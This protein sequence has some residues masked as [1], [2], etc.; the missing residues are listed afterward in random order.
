MKLKSLLNESTKDYRRLNI[1][2]EEKEQKM[3]SEEKKAFL[4][5]VSAYKKFGETIYRNGDL[6]ET[7]TAI[8]GIVENANKVTLEE[9]GDWFDRVT[10]NRHMKSMNESFKVFQKTLTEV[11]TL[12]Q[13]LESTY[14]EIGEVLSKY[15]EIKEGNEF[16]AARAKAIAKGENE[17]E[18]DGKKYPVKSVDK[19]DKENAKEFTNEVSDLEIKK[20]IK[21][22]ERG[23]PYTIIARNGQR[24]VAHSPKSYDKVEDA[25]K[26]YH[27]LNKK[28]GRR[29]SVSIE[30]G[31]GRTVFM[32]SVNE[33][34]SMKLKDLIK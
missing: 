24:I 21:K 15:Y 9:T 27:K 29:S 6:M 2:E 8:K 14:D 30:D 13:R 4:E 5:A 1:G 12:Q 18:V 11:H 20:S 19:D 25:I 10:V 33:S 26:M 22:K 3:T 17:F 34:K 7:Y 16:G 31:F 32:E 28:H 23:G